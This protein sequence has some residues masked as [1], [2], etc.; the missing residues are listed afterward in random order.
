MNSPSLLPPNHTEF[1]RNLETVSSRISDVP[2]DIRDVWNPNTCPT[3]LLPWLAWALSIDNWKDY[4]PESVKRALLNNAIN[5]SQHKGT[6]Q[7]VR[8]VVNSFGVDMTLDETSTN[9]APFQFNIEIN[10]N[11]VGAQ[12]S[13]FTRDVVDE[14]ARTKRSASYFELQQQIKASSPIA[15]TG[16][17]R[18]ARFIRFSATGPERLP[19]ALGE[20]DDQATQ[21]IL[22]GELG[23]P[24]T[25]E[26][27]LGDL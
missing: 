21:P 7:S 5:V 20:L 26:Y 12:N 6:G 15:I 13:D 2:V 11:N 18:V 10:I 17:I 24:V 19:E 14:V 8:D 23:D 3:E 4:W 22:L 1:E 16:C 27:I 9:L 25:K